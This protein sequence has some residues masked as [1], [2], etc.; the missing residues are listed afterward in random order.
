MKYFDEMNKDEILNL[1]GGYIA[2]LLCPIVLP[3]MGFVY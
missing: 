1:N 2:L 3:I